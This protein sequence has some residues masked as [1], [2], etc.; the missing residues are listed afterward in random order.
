MKLNAVADTEDRVFHRRLIKFNGLKNCRFS[1][2]WEQSGG[3][4]GCSFGIVTSSMKNEK[5]LTSRQ[6][7]RVNT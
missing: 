2:R 7:N 1:Q 6:V 3:G 4:F 5:K